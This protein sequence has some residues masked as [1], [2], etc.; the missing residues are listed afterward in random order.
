M[1]TPHPTL[2]MHYEQ[3]HR[4]TLCA[5]RSS[6]YTQHT[7]L[8]VGPLDQFTLPTDSQQLIIRPPM[9]IF[10]L[11]VT[12]NNSIEI[13]CAFSSSRNLLRQFPEA[14]NSSLVLSS[15]RILD[16]PSSSQ[17]LSGTHGNPRRLSEVPR[18]S[19]QPGALISSCRLPCVMNSRV[20]N[21]KSACSEL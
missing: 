4:S 2:A 5:G 20:S 15:R 17:Q 12:P 13:P 7:D 1:I 21:C 10:Q 18:N 3:L 16:A 6:F 8:F 9:F 11:S 14:P 19:Q